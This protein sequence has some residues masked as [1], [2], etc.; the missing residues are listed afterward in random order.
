MMG[1]G[2]K[3]RLYS[4]SCFILA[5]CFTTHTAFVCMICIEEKVVLE[6]L[7][8]ERWGRRGS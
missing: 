7:G 4:C 1:A 3:R 2:I 5:Q 8:K 6:F